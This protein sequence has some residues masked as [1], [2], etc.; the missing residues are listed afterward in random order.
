MYRTVSNPKKQGPPKDVERRAIIRQ[1]HSEGLNDREICRKTGMSHNTVYYF[2]QDMGLKSNIRLNQIS[3]KE[4]RC[5]TCK[6]IKTMDHFSVRKTAFKPLAYT[7]LCHTCYNEYRREYVN[8]DTV[9]YLRYLA[10]RVRSRSKTYG[11]FCDLTEEQIVYL[12][13]LQNGKCFYT[14]VLMTAKMDREDQR[15]KV[16]VDKII[17]S[18]GYTLNNVVLCTAKA[19]TVKSDLNLDEIK[20]WLPTWYER[21]EKY[22]G[23]SK[24]GGI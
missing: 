18:L 23:A 9:S 13:D 22:H 5:S 6:E 12:W 19:N 16:S 4:R 1:L 8:R 7:T 14:D 15:K 11:H 17:P 10:T 24:G 3:D 21:I 20:S 2:R